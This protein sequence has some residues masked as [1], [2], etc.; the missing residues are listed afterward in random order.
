MKTKKNDYR[1]SRRKSTGEVFTPPF[2]VNEMLDKLIE[3]GKEAVTGEDKTFCDP[4]CGNGGML[5]EVLKR[6][7]SF[8]HDPTKALATLYGCDIMRD[9]IGECQLRL[10][11]ILRN[12]GVEIIRKHVRTVMNQIVCTP[13]GQY[14]KGSLDYDFEFR[15]FASDESV[16]VLFAAFQQ[17]SVLQEDRQDLQTASELWFGDCNV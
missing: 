7:L 9:N 10:L 8:G 13:L 16:D 1:A 12:N 15:D 3:S 11:G 6:K 5:V 17:F 4:A 14:K 2:L